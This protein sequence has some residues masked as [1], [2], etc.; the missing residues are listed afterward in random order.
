MKLHLQL[1]HQVPSCL[2]RPEKPISGARYLSMLQTHCSFGPS[3]GAWQRKHGQ[4]LPL[5]TKLGDSVNGNLPRAAV[6]PQASR[7][8]RLDR[9]AKAIVWRL[10]L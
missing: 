8:N 4:T 1:P 2:S 6:A 7:N 10:H 5:K 9:R 3:I